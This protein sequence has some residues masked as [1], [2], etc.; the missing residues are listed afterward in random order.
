MGAEIGPANPA[1]IQ[2]QS[3]NLD[4]LGFTL[5]RTNALAGADIQCIAG[6]SE[7]CSTPHH[8]VNRPASALPASRIFKSVV[9]GVLRRFD[10]PDS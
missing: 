8:V 2:K 9:S 3:Q 7:M 10:T 4:C 5:V 6:I 1:P